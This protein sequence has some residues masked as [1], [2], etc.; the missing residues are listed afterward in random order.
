METIKEDLISTK[1]AAKRLG[2]SHQTLEKWRSQK[3]GPHYLKIG[4]KAVRYRQIDLDAFI[5][6]G[7]ND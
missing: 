3:R 7:E 5:D 4:S 1:A 2:I 6:G